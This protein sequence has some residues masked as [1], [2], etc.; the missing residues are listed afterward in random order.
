VS[1]PVF[2]LDSFALL[3]YLNDETGRSRVQE[4]LALAA[5]GDCRVLL[6]MIN[7]GEVLYITERQ[8][9]L[10]NARRVLSLVENLPL[11]LV[12]AERDL[13]M[14]AAHIKANYPISY[15][16]AFVTALCQRENA[17]VLTG[18]PEFA[19][20]ERLITVEWLVNLTKGD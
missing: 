5:R 9:G 8:R 16:D 13:V 12:E 3:A 15:A 10:N 18:D 20:V 14:D 7:L 19:A 17:I 4:A 11:E 2:V 6:C 1:K